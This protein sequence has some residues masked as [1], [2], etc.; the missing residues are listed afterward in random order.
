M[1]GKALAKNRACCPEPLPISSTVSGV[2]NHF[3]NC[4]RMGALLFSAGWEKFLSS[5]EHSFGAGYSLDRSLASI[6]IG[7]RFLREILL[8]RQAALVL[9]LR[10]SEI[11]D[12]CVNRR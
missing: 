5:M 10:P 7:S 4:A 1:S 12:L 3:C 9:R 6:N 11:A 2:F 8:D